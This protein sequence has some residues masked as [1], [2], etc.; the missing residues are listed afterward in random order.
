MKIRSQLGSLSEECEDLCIRVGFVGPK[1]GEPNFRLIYTSVGTY[2]QGNRFAIAGLNQGGDQTDA[3]TD[4]RNPS[5]SRRRVLSLFERQ[6]ER[7]WRRPRRLP[8]N[9]TGHCHDDGG[10]DSI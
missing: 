1:T 2:E 6:L 3:D 8:T 7:R 9:C 4:D 5:L 10:G